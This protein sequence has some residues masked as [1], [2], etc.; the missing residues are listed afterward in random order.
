MLTP[1]VNAIINNHLLRGITFLFYFY[2]IDLTDFVQY[3]DIIESDK[4][5]IAAYL[6]ATK[7]ALPDIINND[8]KR[9]EM[10]NF[11]IISRFFRI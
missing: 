7:T 5:L 11:I 4:E 6:L 3:Y 10:A 8:L 2:S 1:Q 9:E